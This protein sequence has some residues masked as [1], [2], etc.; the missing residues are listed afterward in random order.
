MR[1]YAKP[2]EIDYMFCNGFTEIAKRFAASLNLQLP[3]IL[4]LDDVI[5]YDGKEF[6]CYSIE[7]FDK[8]F[9]YMG[10]ILTI[11][12]NIKDW[13]VAVEFSKIFDL[14]IH[15]PG[16]A[17]LMAIGVVLDKEYHTLTDVWYETRPADFVEILEAAYNTNPQKYGFAY[18][19]MIGLQAADIDVFT[20]TDLIRREC[21][22]LDTNNSV[23]D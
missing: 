6:K 20:I 23:L 16:E 14:Q 5:V 19:M 18:G 7:E 3:P 4:K 13:K 21:Q 2:Q 12:E 11:R 10:D 9:I 22:T 8:T 1:A 17:F 15:S